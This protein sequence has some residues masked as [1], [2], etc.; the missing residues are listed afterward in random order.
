MA[1]RKSLS[2]LLLCFKSILFEVQLLNR[3]PINWEKILQRF[4]FGMGLVGFTSLIYYSA[5]FIIINEGGNYSYLWAAGEN[6][7]SGFGP[8]ERG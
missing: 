8:A 6:I 1:G 2:P 5:L 4:F 3:N 7:S